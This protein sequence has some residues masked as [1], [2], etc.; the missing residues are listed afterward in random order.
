MSIENNISKKE[1]DIL[2]AKYNLAIEEKKKSF[3]FFGKELLVD[4][5]KYLIESL[6]TQNLK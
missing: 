3:I 1:F 2:V 5:A 6:D 4:Y